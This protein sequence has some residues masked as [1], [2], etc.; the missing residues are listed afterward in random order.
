M[1]LVRGETDLAVDV[2]QELARRA[3]QHR[4]L[5]Q[6][7]RGRVR[8]IFDVEDRVAV[9]G[10]SNPYEMADARRDDLDSAPGLHLPQ[11]QTLQPARALNVCDVFSVGGDGGA[12]NLSGISEL[13]RA[14]GRGRRG[15]IGCGAV[16]PCEKK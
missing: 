15:E 4:D 2:R 10:E 7:T 3:A 14:R 9:G 6:P 5:V 16:S 11:P 1:F 12:Q 13:S 8:T